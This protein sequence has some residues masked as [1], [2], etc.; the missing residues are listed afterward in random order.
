MDAI[1]AFQEVDNQF[2]RFSESGQ[3]DGPRQEYFT[4][5][6]YQ[7]TLER[8][9]A[10]LAIANES[11]GAKKKIYLEYAEG[12]FKALNKELEDPKNPYAKV[13]L[14][15]DAISPIYEESLF[16][17]AQTNIKA[18]RD[19]DAEKDPESSLGKIP[20]SCTSPAATTFR[21]CGIEL[22]MISQRK[23]QPQLALQSFQKAEE[24]SKGDLLSTDQKLDLWIQQALCYRSLGDYDHCILLLSKTINDDA[25]S[26]LR[27]KAMFLRAE[28]YEQQGRHELARKQ[29]ESLA[30]KG[31][32]GEKR[33]NKKCLLSHKHEVNHVH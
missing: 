6:R 24:A 25:V 14:Q 18:G 15:R 21:D 16:G 13:L 26:S 32:I 23:Q 31:D 30:K 10:N 29:L 17:L 2:A 5:V 33:R 1:D 8:A 4:K 11:L 19:G 28:T 7:A 3:L 20:S 22:G 9:L 12:V 27:L